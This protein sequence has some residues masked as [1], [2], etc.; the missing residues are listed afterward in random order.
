MITRKNIKEANFHSTKVYLKVHW[1][2][3]F[4]A[5]THVKKR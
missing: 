5:P 2:S 1:L 3:L 4:Y